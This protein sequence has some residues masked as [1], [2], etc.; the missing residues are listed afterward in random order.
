MGGTVPVRK[1]FN[2]FLSICN[3]SI[4]KRLFDY[5]FWTLDVNITFIIKF[6]LQGLPCK[7]EGEFKPFDH[8]VFLQIRKILFLQG[9]F[10]LR[11]LPTKDFKSFLPSYSIFHSLVFKVF[12]QQVLFPDLFVMIKRGLPAFSDFLF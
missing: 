5:R 3:S 8:S 12:V 1:H 6:I 4:L 2:P 7:F 9:G 10:K 11:K